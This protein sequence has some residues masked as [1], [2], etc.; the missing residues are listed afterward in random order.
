MNHPDLPLYTVLLQQI[1]KPYRNYIRHA[2]KD[3]SVAWYMPSLT[4]EKEFEDKW[5]TQQG[6]KRIRSIKDKNAVIALQFESEGVFTMWMLK[7]A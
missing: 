6:I 2:I 5:F 1:M 7:W 3:N 4:I